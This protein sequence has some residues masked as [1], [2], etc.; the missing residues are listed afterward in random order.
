MNKL[1]TLI[2]TIQRLKLIVFTV[3]FTAISIAGQVN[4]IDKDFFSGNDIL[5]YDPTCA[6]TG[7][8]TTLDGNGIK[9]KIWNFLHSEGLDDI[10]TAGVMGNMDAESGYVPTRHQSTGDVYA[11]GGS[12]N[13]WGLVQ[14]DGGRRYTSPDKGVLGKLKKDHSELVK[15]TDIQFDWARNK[16]AQAKIP[17]TDLDALLSFELT[18]LV[19]E[20]KSRPV[21]AHG[22][23]DAGN[24]WNTMK[25]QKNIEDATVF[26][27]NNFEV[28]SDSAAQVISN[29]G[30][31]AKDIY[32][33]FAGKTTTTNGSS[34]GSSSGSSTTPSAAGTP[35]V[36]FIDP[37]H[38]GAIAPYTDPQSG[39]MTAESPNAPESADV[40]DVS[41]RVKTSLEADGYKVVLARTTNDQQVK[42][43]DRANAAAS[44]GASIGVSIHTTPGDVNEAW[45]QRLGAYREYGSHKD[46][47]TEKDTAQKSEMFA[48]IFA[49]T[50]TASEGHSVTTDPGN[51]RQKASFSRADLKSKGN[52]ALIE[53]WSPKVPWVYN[54]IGQDKGTA[55][56]DP[57]KQKYAD[58]ITKGIEES[59]PYTKK[60]QCGNAPAVGGD[61]DKT[62]LGYAWPKYK[63][64]TIDAT[65][66]YTSEVI[67][68]KD[69]DRYIGGNAHPG[70]DCGGFVTNIIINSGFDKNY[71]YG[72]SMSKGAGNTTNQ[73]QWASKNWQTLGKGGSFDTAT[74]H[75]GDVAISGH[76]TF[77]YV[78]KVDG[79]DSNR[80][81]ASLD[82]R[83][84]MAGKE[85]LIDSDFTWYR[86]K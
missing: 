14:W 79:F 8:N 1:R 62:L 2:P 26:W 49:K 27:H 73:A 84:P 65:D 40:L 28:S 83:A 20:S 16:G 13:A 31:K 7:G 71:N 29:R 30:G 32:T 60:D 70:I 18:Y 74:L 72:G 24:E 76:H 81:S 11:N 15:Y 63:G 21:T 68:R 80:A 19:Q 12:G 57:L 41:N 6:Y 61:F 77:V 58:G 85:S 34:S 38:G 56:S 53:L 82:E 46:T 3:L 50:R 55:I 54:E 47:F 48:N 35:P 78:G 75:K 42:F 45:P 64:L 25:L 10:Q 36:I 59:V 39:L 52:I 44:N 23:G 86:K 22:Y 69:K 43:R 37:G 67:H 4:A 51:V 66:L 9:E 5:F 33:Q 17:Q